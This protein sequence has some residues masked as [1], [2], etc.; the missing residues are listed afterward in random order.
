MTAVGIDAMEIRTG[1][2]K[3]DLPNTV[4]P[5]KGDDAKKYTKGLELYNSSLADVYEN[6]ATMGAKA[7]KSLV[8]RN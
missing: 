7:A 5:E 2:R 3:H 1:R 8:E 6:I 4:A